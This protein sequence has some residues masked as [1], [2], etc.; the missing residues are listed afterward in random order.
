MSVLLDVTSAL[1]FGETIKLKWLLWINIFETNEGLWLVNWDYFHGT[2][3]YTQDY[4]IGSSDNYSTILD[5]PRMILLYMIEHERVEL[6][7]S[8]N[9]KSSDSQFRLKNRQRQHKSDYFNG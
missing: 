8:T 2:Q 9:E 3:I 7:Y 5:Y 1:L 4:L 6:S